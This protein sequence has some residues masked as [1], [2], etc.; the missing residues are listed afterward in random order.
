MPNKNTYPYAVQVGVRPFYRVKVN[1]A[2]GGHGAVPAF[3]EGK[4][5]GALSATNTLYKRRKFHR[6]SG[7]DT[8]KLRQ[9]TPYIDRTKTC[10]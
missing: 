7:Q 5:R 6:S 1:K 2:K 3:R 10:P 9:E 4:E 8:P